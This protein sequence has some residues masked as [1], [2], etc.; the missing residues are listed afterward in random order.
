MQS[1]RA[2]ARRRAGLLLAGLVLLSGCGAAPG[3]RSA[4]D[5][6]RSEPDRPVRYMPL[7]DSITEGYP[8][9]QGG[10]RTL[11]WQLLVQQDGDRIDFVG[12]QSSGPPGLGDPDNE[13]H[14]GW[15]IAGPCGGHPDRAVAPRIRGWITQYRPDVVS[16][17]LGTNDLNKGADGTETARR[18]DAL[19]GQ[20]YDADPDVH[21]VLVQIV[22]E[23]GRAEQHAVYNA[24]IPTI[25]DRYRAQGRSVAVVDLAPLLS[26]PTN[27]VDGI[28]PTQFGYDIMA[29]ALH[30]AVSRAY[31][32]VVAARS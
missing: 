14:G 24:A 12:S 30:P 26:M 3:L 27:F 32:D 25:A 16:V 23:Q 21:L 9:M 1:T 20:I 29:R 31:R 7:G 19:V 28:H 17:H 18:L 4:A 5:P 13:G 10:Y 22:E 8:G 6:P 11:L 2:T 15:C